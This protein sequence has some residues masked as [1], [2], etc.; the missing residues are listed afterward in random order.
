VTDTEVGGKVIRAGDRVICNYVAANR[1]PAE[2][3]D[4]EEFRLDRGR[5]RLMTFGAGPHRCLGS[6]MARMTL[7]IMVEELLA[8]VRSVRFA[9]GGKEERVSLNAQAW[10]SVARLPVVL[11]PLDSG[12]RSVA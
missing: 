1:D 3:E 2:W 11:E 7:R 5:N 12:V 9:A 8:R 10:R 6:N 4:P